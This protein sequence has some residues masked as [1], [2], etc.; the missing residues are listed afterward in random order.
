MNTPRSLAVA[1]FVA[2][3]ALALSGTANA[4]SVEPAKQAPPTPEAVAE[5]LRENGVEIVAGE[6]GSIHLRRIEVASDGAAEDADASGADEALESQPT[7]LPTG[8]VVVPATE[9]PDVCLSPH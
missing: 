1:G 9:V 6:T 7:R 5:C 3:G 2:L 8:E 4:A